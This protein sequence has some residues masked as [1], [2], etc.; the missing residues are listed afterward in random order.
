MLGDKKSGKTTLL[1][2]FKNPK[3]KLINDPLPT[4]GIDY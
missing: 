4:F 2:K 1:E 3:S